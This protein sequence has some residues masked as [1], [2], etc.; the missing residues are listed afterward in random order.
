VGLLYFTLEMF[1]VCPMVDM[2]HI[3]TI[4]KFLPQTRVN[5]DASI[6]F[7][8]TMIRA[9]RSARSCDL[10]CRLV[11]L[12]TFARNVRRTVTTDLLV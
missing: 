6:N 11:L 10:V 8:A 3:D 7:A 4:F 1:A 5:M 9:F 2:T 12:R